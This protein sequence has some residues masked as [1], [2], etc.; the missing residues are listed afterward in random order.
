MQL[1]PDPQITSRDHYGGRPLRR[2]A[3]EDPLP[4]PRSGRHPELAPG[5][6]GSEPEGTAEGRGPDDEVGPGLRQTDADAVLAVSAKSMHPPGA[7]NR[8]TPARNHSP[9]KLLGSRAL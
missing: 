1:D 6:A 2:S 7:G 4:R 9:R 5:E 3:I 8:S